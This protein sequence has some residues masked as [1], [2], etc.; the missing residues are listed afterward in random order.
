MSPG[1]R[2]PMLSLQAAGQHRN[3]MHT[4]SLHVS[5][6]RCHTCLFSPQHTVRNAFTSWCRTCSETYIYVPQAATPLLGGPSPGCPQPPHSWFSPSGLLGAHRKTRS[7]R[8]SFYSL[9]PIPPRGLHQGQKGLER[10]P[11]PFLT[12]TRLSRQELRTQTDFGQV[13]Q[14][15]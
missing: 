7:H 2:S 6:E 9:H 15:L 3:Y 14:F 12:G 5:Q 13:T 1:H 4:L 10:L 11:C 8:T